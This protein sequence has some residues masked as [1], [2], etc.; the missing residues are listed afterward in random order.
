M[1]EEERNRGSS[2]RYL[3][4]AVICL[5]LMAFLQGLH[6]FF[7][8]LFFWPAL[9]FGVLAVYYRVVA[10]RQ[11]QGNT[12]QWQRPAAAPVTRR[13]VPL[14]AIIGAITLII[15]VII[16]FSRRDNSDS[17]QTQRVDAKSDEVKEDN[18]S[19]YQQALQEFNNQNYRK[20]ITIARRGLTTSPGSNDLMLVLGDAYGAMK[21]NDSSFVWFDRA[22]QNGARSAYLSHWLGYL[23]DE[24]GNRT[25]ALKFYKDALQQDSSRTQVYDRLAELEPDRA[26]WYKQQST[27]WAK[28]K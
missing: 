10:N 8:A 25:L 22:Y 28:T 1:Q 2:R 13:P 15:F 16:M 23:H 12:A 11:E 14:P 27:K 9:G 19:E 17:T 18:P 7:F 5:Y 24:T 26:A 21:I 3:R 6:S 20:S 4:L